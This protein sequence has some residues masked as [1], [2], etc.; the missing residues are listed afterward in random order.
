MKFTLHLLLVALFVVFA[1]AVAEQKQVI[2]SY[3][4]NTPNSVIEQAKAAIK[5]AVSPPI[6]SPTRTFIDLG[7]RAASSHM[8]T[9]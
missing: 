1:Y 5:E 4:N 6:F 3:P 9:T 7:F 2:V 8:S